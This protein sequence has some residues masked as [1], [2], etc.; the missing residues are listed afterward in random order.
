MTLR[1]PIEVFKEH[2][3]SSMRP[4]TRESYG[5]LFKNLG[6]LLGDISVNPKNAAGVSIT[7]AFFGFTGRPLTA[8]G[9]ILW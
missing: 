1:Q 7:A 4:K 2:Q 5:H 8:E 6:V 3:K 9:T